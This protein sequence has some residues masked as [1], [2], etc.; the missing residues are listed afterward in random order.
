MGE[1]LKLENQRM[2]E[3]ALLKAERDSLEKAKKEAE[4]I[5]LLREENKR[6]K[7]LAKNNKTKKKAV[8]PAQ[9]PSSSKPKSNA[10]TLFA[11]T[12]PKGIRPGQTFKVSVKGTEYVVTCPANAKSGTTIHVPIKMSVSRTTATMYAVKVP[13]GVRAGKTF[14][15][16]A[17]GKT[18][19][20]TCPKSAKPG[21]TIRV[22][23]R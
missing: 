7:R 11:A 3:F 16:K 18:Y 2:Q 4:E 23:L 12:V 20:V 15:V 17:K 22:P 13:S 9:A 14:N 1:R 6:L 8:A 21:T 5:G 10:P 19:K